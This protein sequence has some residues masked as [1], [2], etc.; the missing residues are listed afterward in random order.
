M[1]PSYK[2]TIFY[3]LVLLLIVCQLDNSM[4]LVLATGVLAIVWGVHLRLLFQRTERTYWGNVREPVAIIDWG[5][6]G[7]SLALPAH[8]SGQYVLCPG[9]R[10]QDKKLDIETAL[11]SAHNP[12]FLEYSLP[13]YV[14]YFRKGER[15]NESPEEYREEVIR[16]MNTER[17]R[18]HKRM[19]QSVPDWYRGVYLEG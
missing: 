17:V 13:V 2:I 15:C 9:Y 7:P 14:I 5:L 4:P 19:D 3:L 11:Q 18:W 16:I 8:L 1:T 12:L 6:D 10:V